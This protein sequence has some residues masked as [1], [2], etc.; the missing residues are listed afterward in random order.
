MFAPPSLSNPYQGSVNP[1]PFIAPVTPEQQKDY[2]FQL[3]I[4]ADVINPDF[5]SAYMQQW[6][7]SFQRELGKDFLI[8][9]AYAGSKGTAL[10]YDIQINPAIYNGPSSTVGNTNQRRPLWPTYGSLS[11]NRA[12]ANSIYNSMQWS[13]NKRFSYGYSI[14]AS[15]TWSKAIDTISTG[16]EGQFKRVPNPYDLNAYRGLADFD[17]PHRFVSSFVWQL[18]V[19][20]SQHGVAGRLLGGWAVS[21]IVTLQSGQPFS[22]LSGTDRSFSAVG[23]D[24]ADLVGDPFLSSG[25]PRGERIAEYFNTAALTQA[26][27]G[28]FGSA[29]RNILRGF[30]AKDVTL[31]F[32]KDTRI[33]ERQKLQFRAEFFNLFNRPTFALPEARAN[34]KSFGKVLSA[35]D[36]RVVQ[37]VLKYMF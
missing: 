31:S 25:R 5:H 20:Q 16:R 7:V 4:I 19:L 30:P 9:G 8:T 6:N 17:Y 2:G 12:G 22:A 33:L 23:G 34:N 21:G 26:A 15:Y 3:P 36:G 13:L 14:L 32:T 18:P 24:L 29:G 35:G 37:M 27:A 11:E 1:F 28:T 10:H